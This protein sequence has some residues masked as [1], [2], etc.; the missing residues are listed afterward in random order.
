[1]RL[2]IN[3]AQIRGEDVRFVLFTSDD[4]GK[5]VNQTKTL[6]DDKILGDEFIDI[7]FCGLLPQHNYSLK[8]LLPDQQEKL[9]FENTPF[10]DLID[11]QL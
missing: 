4:S 7:D 5:A 3:P 2:N 11:E 9:I 8:I 6:L 1:M 10:E